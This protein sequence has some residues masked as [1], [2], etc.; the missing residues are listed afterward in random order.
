MAAS[1]ATITSKGQV[2]IPKEIRLA[3]RLNESDNVLFIVEGDRA[4]IVP[5]RRRALSSFRG[6]L[7]AT[8]VYP[9]QASIRDELQGKLGEQISRGEE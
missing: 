2:T 6:V 7:P 9:G 8:R 1:L 4:V 5:L 3:L